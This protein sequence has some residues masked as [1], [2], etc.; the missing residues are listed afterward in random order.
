MEK[1]IGI[2]MADLSGYTALTET[3]GSLSAA[4]LIDKYVDIVEN[5]LVGDC[6]LHQRVGDEVVIVSSSPDY[7]VATALMILLNTSS[8]EYFLQVHGGLHYGKVLQRSDS[9]FGSALNLTSRIAAKASAGSV[10]CSDDFVNALSDRSMFNL[11]SKG[12]H[13]F[14]NINGK[15]EVFELSFEQKQSFYIDP[16]CR[17]VI[18]DT[19]QAIAHPT[20]KGQYFCSPACL[21][22]HGHRNTKKYS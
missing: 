11:I 4:D 6:M 9:Y 7:L 1:N 3:H 8:E 18:L 14:K 15:K 21:E 19:E 13:D 22:L 12:S 5:C 10:L 20:E 16:I 2:L 17:M